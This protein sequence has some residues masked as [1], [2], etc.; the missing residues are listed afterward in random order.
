ME[1][2]PRQVVP[3]Y[4]AAGL[5]AI[6]VVAAN[7]AGGKGL[8]TGDLE[9][10]LLQTRNEYYSPQPTSMEALPSKLVKGDTEVVPWRHQPPTSGFRSVE[11]RD[12]PE[13]PARWRSWRRRNWRRQSIAAPAAPGSPRRN[14]PDDW[15]RASPDA[16]ASRSTRSH[17]PG[18][19]HRR[20]WSPD[21]LRGPGSRVDTR[22][23]AAS[24]MWRGSEQQHPW[25]RGLPSPS[26]RYA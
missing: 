22:H 24:H 16:V 20:R 26:P 21:P 23:E 9:R 15:R 12:V 6:R 8:V 10:G 7:P 4:S 1:T 3:I 5:P 17:S 25:G 13:S 14:G 19:A 11:E 18:V 2:L